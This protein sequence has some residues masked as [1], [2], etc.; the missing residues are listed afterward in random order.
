LLCRN[1]PELF[2]RLTAQILLPERGSYPMSN[3][4]VLI[5]EDDY[6]ITELARYVLEEK[7]YRVIVLQNTDGI[8]PIIEKAKPDL[9]LLDLWMPGLSGEEVTRRLK[10]DKKTRAIPVIIMSANKDTARI[11]KQSGA[12]G[13]LAKPFDIAHLENLVD[14]H[15]VRRK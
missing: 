6:S 10:S 9:I 15:L 13:Y 4:C 8:F 14:S 7:G 5:C 1:K 11:A 2:K 12:D 3:K